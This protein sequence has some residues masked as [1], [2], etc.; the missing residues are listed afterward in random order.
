MRFR[1]VLLT[2]C[3]L[4]VASTTYAK[5]IVHIDASKPASEKKALLILPGFGSI[6]H[7]VKHI[8]A[9]Y[10]DRGYDLFIPDYISRKSVA[11]CTANLD[12]FLKE[13]RLDE[14]K[15]LHV[16]SY[17]IGAWSFNDWLK[18]SE[19]NNLKTI[20]Y[21]RSPLQERAPYVLVK[22]VPFLARIVGGRAIKDMS[23]IPYPTVQHSS[24]VK[25]G[26][27]IET[28]PTKLIIRHKESAYAL[29]PLSWEVEDLN[30]PHSDY[31]FIPYNHDD[32]YEEFE[33]AGREV[34]YFFKNGEFSPQASKEK[35]TSNPL[36]P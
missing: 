16:L 2:M 23:D 19:L 11:K 36:Q 30:Q 25:V 26:L 31:I 17:L 15:E 29:G 8:E 32:L 21:D 18:T 3:L 34:M 6:A 20:V 27:L 12:D 28:I 10:K 1:L 9:Y 4:Q 13:Y 5:D 7:G 33:S 24:Q 22:D 35:P 14:Y